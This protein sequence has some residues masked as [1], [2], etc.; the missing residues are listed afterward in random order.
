MAPS[1]PRHTGEHQGISWSGQGSRRLWRR[2]RRSTALDTLPVVLLAIIAGAGPFTHIRDT[3]GHGQHKP[4]SRAAEHTSTKKE[5]N[6]ARPDRS[7]KQDFRAWAAA[8]A[9]TLPQLTEPQVAAVAR[10]AALLDADD[11][12]KPAA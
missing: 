3:A 9:A 11:S 10:L 2:R 4:A 7:S 6:T 12:Q 8:V 1:L 5:A